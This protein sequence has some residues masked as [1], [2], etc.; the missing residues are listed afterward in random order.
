MTKVQE[1]QKKI[2]LEFLLLSSMSF[3]SSPTSIYN[4]LFFKKLIQI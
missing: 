3:M 1:L 2:K 4:R